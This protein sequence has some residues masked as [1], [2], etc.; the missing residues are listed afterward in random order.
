MLTM[1]PDARR[2]VARATERARRPK[3]I[4]P[5]ASSNIAF[6]RNRGDASPVTTTMPPPPERRRSVGFWIA[7]GLCAVIFIALVGGAVGFL[8]KSSDGAAPPPPP[9]PPSH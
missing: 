5:E 7:I 2:Q 8:G 4:S 6:A 1:H 3:A 9:P